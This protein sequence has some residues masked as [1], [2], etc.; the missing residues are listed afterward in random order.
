M[1]WKM[2]ELGSRIAS[3]NSED[4][5]ISVELSCLIK[6]K[7]IDLQHNLVQLNANMSWNR[8]AALA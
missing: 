3:M 7:A 5:L 1:G 8:L 4:P 6:A 2:N